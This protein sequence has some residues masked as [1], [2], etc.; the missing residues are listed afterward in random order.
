MILNFNK[1]MILNFNKVMILNFNKVM[2]LNFNKVMIVLSLTEYR[3]LNHKIIK[4]MQIPL[5]DLDELEKYRFI[6]G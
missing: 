6:D 1:V 5:I 2:I 4:K 3:E